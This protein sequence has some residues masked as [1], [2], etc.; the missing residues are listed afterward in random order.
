MI[1]TDTI[2]PV[3]PDRSRVRF[4]RRM[5]ERGDD[6][7]QKAAVIT[8]PGDHHDPE[9]P[10]VEDRVDED[11]E[12]PADAGRSPACSDDLPERR[13]DGLL[14]EHAQSDGQGAVVEVEGQVLG[15]GL[16]EAAADLHLAVERRE[17]GL[18]GLDERSRLDL[19]VEVDG[20]RT[21]GTAPGPP[22]PTASPP[23]RSVAHRPLADRR[24]EHGCGRGDGAALRAAR[25]PGRSA[26]TA[27]PRP[28]DRRGAAPS[29]SDRRS[30]WTGRGRTPDWP[31]CCWRVGWC[32]CSRSGWPPWWRIR[33]H[34][35]SG[36]VGGDFALGR[37]RVGRGAAQHRPE[38]ELG[39]GAD[40]LDEGA[41][42]LQTRELHHDVAALGVHGRPRHARPRRHGCG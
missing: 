32:S 42:V 27:G 23:L 2:T 10:V 16:G 15:R 39:R 12:Q 33:P 37:R 19:A 35:G 28:A 30:S 20:R 22:C 31:G 41:G 5:P 34:A 17:R 25:D 8:R 26:G 1:P 18:A 36:P 21:G 4:E 7:P 3:T 29:V 40:Q 6:G 9:R 38:V 11:Q 24:V 13:R 14:G